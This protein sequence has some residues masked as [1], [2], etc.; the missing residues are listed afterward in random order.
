MGWG[1]SGEYEG[2]LVIR[3][4]IPDQATHLSTRGDTHKHDETQVSKMGQRR[5]GGG[6][7]DQD[8]HR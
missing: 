3:D 1:G 2:T 8:R 7:S 5:L 6:I 4:N